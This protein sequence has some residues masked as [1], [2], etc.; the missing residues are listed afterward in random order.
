MRQAQVKSDSLL[1]LSLC[2]SLA[3]AVKQVWSP[4]WYLRV[5][6]QT[7]VDLSKFLQGTP[8]PVSPVLVEYWL[9]VHKAPGV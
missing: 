9:R 4:L 2:S 1:A 8:D 6:M 7:P 5:R 3:L